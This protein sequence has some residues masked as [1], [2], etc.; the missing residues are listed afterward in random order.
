MARR[1]TVEEIDEKISYMRKVLKNCY[2]RTSI[3]VGFPGE[4]EENFNNLYEFVKRTRFD[5]MGVF[6]YSCEEG[7]A[8]AEFPDQVDDDVKQER[9][10]KLMS[11]QQ[12]ISLELNRA[13]IGSTID[14]IV[15]GY[16]EENFL[17]YGRSRG[18]SIDV[19]GKV[20]FGTEEDVS[21]G[22]IINVEILDAS[23]YDLTGQRV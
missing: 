4:T 7:T 10:D 14:V 2:I 15:E 12:G 5:R 17:F 8:A 9:Y 1:T 18:D 21:P 6:T 13:K 22:D 23:E 20:Y 16:D 3:I 11:L 19:D